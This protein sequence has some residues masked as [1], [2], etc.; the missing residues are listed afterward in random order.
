[1]AAIPTKLNLGTEAPPFAL[2]DV[3]TG[4]VVS[5]DHLT[6]G[7]LLVIWICNHCPY[8]KR[9]REGL[10]SLGKDYAGS[11][12]DMVA[13]SSNDAENYPDDSPEELARIADEVG[14]PFPVLFDETQDV[15][16]A[17][18]AVCTPDFFLF[19]A[20][21]LLV[22]RGQFDAA[23]PGNELAVTGVDL[24]AAIDA[25]LA[26]EAVPGDQTPPIGC[27]IKWKPGTEAAV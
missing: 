1:M 15:A 26:G 23:R 16:K 14:Y 5:S 4:K 24:R 21:R 10:V 27:S 7:P 22:Y 9:V 17:Y 11:P 25:V 19:D 12:V 8:V 13:I 2:P 3:R 20:H 18:G 6:A